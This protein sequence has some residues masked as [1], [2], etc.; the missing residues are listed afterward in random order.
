MLEPRAVSI[1]IEECIR[2]IDL[3]AIKIKIAAESG[4]RDL[5]DFKKLYFPRGAEWLIDQGQQL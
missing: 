1:I 3:A 5:R 2:E 4:I